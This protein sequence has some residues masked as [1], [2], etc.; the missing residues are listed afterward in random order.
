LPVFDEIAQAQFG[1]PDHIGLEASP[2]KLAP[3]A[4]S[5]EIDG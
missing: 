5:G 4:Q 1:D 2:K 3:D